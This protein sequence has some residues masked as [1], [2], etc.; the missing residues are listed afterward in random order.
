M[1]ASTLSHLSRPGALARGLLCAALLA[2]AAGCAQEEP[3]PTPAPEAAAAP[4]QE[5]AP[6]D[7]TL[8]LLAG[9]V[10]D[11][12]AVVKLRFQRHPGLEGPRAAE[13]FLQTSDNLRLAQGQSLQAAQEAGKELVVQEPSPG[14]LRVILYATANLEPIDSGELAALRFQRTGPGRASVDFV[15]GQVNLAPA[16]AARGMRLSQELV[17]EE[18]P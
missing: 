10:N 17:L 8:A 7:T 2:L 11:Q 4:R 6:Q 18:A 12:E 14:L 1:I 3:A 15:S 5:D 9:E 13:I 16:Q